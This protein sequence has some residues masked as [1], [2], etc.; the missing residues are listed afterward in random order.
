M[1]ARKR[2]IELR[3]SIVTRAND[4]KEKLDAYEI[5]GGKDVPSFREE[6]LGI[7]QGIHAIDIKPDHSRPN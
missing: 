7:F 5:E 4:L 2:A 3:D 6:M 1:A